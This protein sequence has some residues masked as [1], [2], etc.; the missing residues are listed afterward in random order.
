MKLKILGLGLSVIALMGIGAGTASATTLVIGGSPSASPIT[1]T[2]SI[3]PIST[4]YLSSTSGSL[5]S[6]CKESHF[7]GSAPNGTSSKVTGSISSLSFTK[8]D[9]AGVQVH[10]AG[11]LYVEY[12]FGTNGD[13]FSEEAEITV[14]TTA[15]ITANCKTGSG[16]TIGELEGVKSGHAT[17]SLVAILNCGFL[18]PSAVWSGTYIVTSPTGL[19]V[20]K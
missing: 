5:S 10:K 17:L 19:G 11:N 8:C 6:T 4:S 7:H 15:G 18:L 1:I 20:E 3:E 12:T 16:T 13:V 9:P 2:A 14:P